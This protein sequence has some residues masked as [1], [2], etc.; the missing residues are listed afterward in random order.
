MEN[1]RYR[2]AL[3]P[4]LAALTIL[5]AVLPLDALPRFG[6]W[7]RELSLSG[8]AGNLAAWGIALGLTA[9]PALGL[10]WR[11]RCRWDWLL[12]LASAEIFAGVFFLVNPSMLHPVFRGETAGKAWGLAAAG[13][14]ASALL[15]WA[16]LR[17][18]GRLREAASPGRTI[19]GLLRGAALLLG[20]L[21]AWEQGAVL[22]ERIREAAQSNTGPGALLWPTNLVLCLLA[23][24][25]LLPELL[26]C[27]LLVWGCGLA[28]ALEENPFGGETVAAAESLSRRCGQVAGISVLLCA[29]GNL[30][31]MLLFSAL[32]SAHFT[33]SFPV[34][35]VLLS[36]ALGLLCRY[37]RR[38]KAVS[39]DNETII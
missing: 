22:L 18:L 20:W 21:A 14:A 5:A 35:T 28:R 3:L 8:A 15:A 33:V 32:R 34:P 2:A 10:L 31:Q 11:G 9:L 25:N 30:V 37:F 26:G 29:G 4:S 38:A 39:D 12:V 13:S 17:G 7:L 23:A 27:G 19:A 6:G 24:A 1:K 36:A 16:V